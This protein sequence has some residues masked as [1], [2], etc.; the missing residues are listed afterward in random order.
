[1][2]YGLLFFISLFVFPAYAQLGA[3]NLAIEQVPNFVH[4]DRG[5]SDEKRSSR[6]EWSSIF[7]RDS[8][9][10]HLLGAEIGLSNDWAL[11]LNAVS[12][13]SE[14]VST[15]STFQ[16]GADHDIDDRSSI[17]FGILYMREPAD[18]IGRGATIGMDRAFDTP[19]LNAKRTTLTI[20]GTIL[21][22]RQFGRL[23]NRIRQNYVSQNS[24]FLDGHQELLE[25]FNVGVSVTRFAVG[26]GSPEELS[27]AI[28]NRPNV[29][30]GLLTVVNGF[31]RQNTSARA[32]FEA[33]DKLLTTLEVFQTNYASS[34]FTRGAM[35]SA[36]YDITRHWRL[37]GGVSG[38]KDSN[39]NRGG[40]ILLLGAAYTL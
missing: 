19:F 34:Y 39:G 4:G 9:R 6:L 12:Q 18:V 13:K 14:R 10:S 5:L 30:N 26:G 11:L 37:T 38:T 21:R 20:Q 8:Y 36:L 3:P 25:R 17:N 7:A 23:S 28:S 15:A 2:V 16:A 35:V 32:E 22:Y 1:M 27:Q 33:S 24:V 31:P 40:G 29:S